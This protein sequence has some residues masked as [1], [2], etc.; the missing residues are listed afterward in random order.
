MLAI[1]KTDDDFL[2]RQVIEL[3]SQNIESGTLAPGDRLPSLRK[4]SQRAGVSVPTVRQAYIELERQRRIESRPQS[5][6]YVRH[7]QRNELVRP[8]PSSS[9][10]PVKLCCRPLMQRVY[11]GINNPALVP[12]GIA[13]P[14]MCRTAAKGLNRAMKRVMARAEEAGLGYAS[15]VGEDKLRRQ[16]AYHYF[17][18]VGVQVEPESIVITNGGQEALL[19]ALRAVAEPGDVIAVETPTYHGLLELIDSLDMLAV[20]VE[21]CPE[22]GVELA[23]LQKVLE[24]HPV[25]ACMFS[26]TLSNPLGVGM[27]DEDRKRL[28]K[29]LEDYD[30]T[31]IEDDVYGDLRFD[32]SRPTPAG[33]L[34]SNAK[35]LTCGSFS[36]TVAPGYRMGWVLAEH[37]LDEITR[38]K[39][40]FSCSS[41]LL[42]QL[43]LADF[44]AS[45][46]YQRHLKALRP[47]LKANCE[48]MSAAIAQHFP[49][50]TRVSQPQG[51]GV[52]WLELPKGVDSVELFDDAIDA[53]ISLTPGQIFSPSRRYRNFLRLSYG[54]PWQ[55][56]FEEA[57][58]WL[59]KST[60]S[61]P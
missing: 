53:G 51:G 15:T 49:K 17:D 28:V 55:P 58:Q 11:D 42:A 13:N 22:E 20:E 3:I 39:R 27:P 48:R 34:G 4:M 25:K 45:G 46:D 12:F 1:D 10:N 44:L 5:G 57:I 41:G 54:H 52:L 18:T 24:K 8:G 37:H 6:F 43:T 60:S 31:L 36:K 21:T 40:A 56:R 33:L 16:I 59:G 38:L 29:L 14:T 9:G 23:E 50:D 19:L 26:T 47:A 2:Y 35:I 30:V 61:H 32:G 7:V